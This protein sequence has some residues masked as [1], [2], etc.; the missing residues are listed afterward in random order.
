M[1]KFCVSTAVFFLTLTL[2][3]GCSKPQAEQPGASTVP[4]APPTQAT[5]PPEQPGVPLLDQG[6]VSGETGN[7]LY[8]PNP[9]VE[10]MI[11]PEMRLYGNSLLL[12]EH[13]GD[14]MVQLKRISLEDG[15]LLAQAAYPAVSGVTVQI[16]SGLIALCDRES[17][18]VHFLNEFL[19][20]ETIYPVSLAGEHWYLNQEMETLYVFSRE[21]GLLSYHLETG[22]TR[23]L[24]DNATSVQILGAG[25]GFILFSYTDRADN[26]TYTRCLNLSTSGLETIPL[27]SPI[28]SGVR[29]GELWLMQEVDSGAYILV[30]QEAAVSFPQPEGT[31]QLLSG[32]RQL[33]VTGRSGRELTVYDPAGKFLSQCTLP[34][35]ENAEVGTDLVWSGYWQGYFFRGTYGDAAHLMFWNTAAEQEGTDLS[36]TSLGTV[37]APKPIMDKDLY[38]RVQTLSQRFG[39]DIRIAEQCALEYSHYRAEALEDPYWV[40]NALT[41]LEQ[42]LERYPEG[43]ISQLPFGDLAQIRIELVANLQGQD[44]MDTHPLSIGGF[45]QT[46]DDHYLIVFDGFSLSEQTVY[47]ELSHVIDKHLAWDAA[48]RPQA[49]FSEEAWLSLQPKG[50]RYAGSYVDM[51]EAIAAY[52]SSGYFAS[53]YAMTFPTEDRATL[54]ELMMADRTVVTENP[55]MAEKMRY[56]AACIRDCFN[57]D[58]WPDRTLWEW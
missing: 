28:V 56:Y 22:E 34:Q 47:H 41:V 40:R 55:G 44:A 7:L 42:A 14:G 11:H 58:D 31:V 1:K 39:L 32:R 30:D 46:V 15:T 45:A 29:S 17:N 52:E 54:M 10:S 8:I 9:H 27:E 48:Q 3:I 13:T 20:S 37:Q 33:L 21:E 18:Q 12:Y 51:P 2:L 43:F 38:R 19:E 5:L 36:V 26:M 16:G 57:T 6:E 53:L 49:L 23:Y 24:V 50:F 4:T 35:A 25:S